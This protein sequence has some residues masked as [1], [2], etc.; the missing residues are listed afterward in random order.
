MALLFVLAAVALAAPAQA[1]TSVEL[2]SNFSETQ[3]GA[4]SLSSFDQAQE[5]T[6]GTNSGGYK[7]TSI[8]LE[9]SGN[10]TGGGSIAVSIHSDSSGNPG[11]SLGALGTATAVGSIRTFKKTSTTG[12][13]AASTTYFVV[14]DVT[15]ELNSNV[16]NTSSDNESSTV[17]WTIANGSVYRLNASTT[18]DWTN[19][20]D[21]KR[22]R[23]NGYA[24]TGTDTTA[25]AF[26]SA[27]AN[28]AAL[29]IT[30]DED[31]AAAASLA[32]SAFTVKKT[33]SGGSEATV[34]LST[35]V[36]P[37]ISGTTVTLTLGTALVSTD[38]SVKV[39]YTKPTT[40]SA[41]K[42]VDAAGNETATFTDQTVTN[43]TPAASCT[44]P[45]FGTRR[46]IWT[47]SLTVGSTTGL[48]GFQGTIIGALD[49]KTFSIG[50]SDHEIDAISLDVRG[51]PNLGLT[52]SLKDTDLTS[53][54]KAALRL[55]VC[56]TATVDFSAASH[57]A[58]HH[59]YSATYSGAAWT[60]GS[61]LA[62]Y[63]SLPANN[64]ATGAPEISGAALVGETL[65][66]TKGTIADADGVPTTL[67]YQWLR[68]DGSNETDI[69]G[70]TEST[71]TVS[72]D[73][74]GKTLKVKVGFTDNFDSEESR[75]SAATATVAQPP[76]V[77]IAAVYPKAAP[78]SP[79]RSSG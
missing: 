66:A 8:V 47:G 76:T 29:V 61:T 41:N 15:G 52:F 55:H 50:S 49:D 73:D 42:L 35:S 75:T 45:S 60:S 57:I 56:N 44:A 21:P 23:I 1:Q 48:V 64:A 77:S 37:V 24:K 40:G 67:T 65:M 68:V 59:T 72:A 71:Y 58:T 11:T 32:N 9:L 7:L 69:T 28:G 31:L 38:G 13:L 63:L 17:G 20:S 26:A 5:F 2:V 30:F 39:T 53:A 10:G 3:S 78:A 51:A 27:A 34:A 54:E 74:I 14:V 6:T 4:G 46:N 16:S 22:I 18:G 19:F 25:P 70:A 79:I 36:A 43:N 33:A 62:V 12:V